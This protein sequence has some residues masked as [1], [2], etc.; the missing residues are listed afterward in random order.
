MNTQQRFLDKYDEMR[1]LQRRFF[2]GDRSVVGQAKAAERE[3]DALALQ[4]RAEASQLT[5]FTKEP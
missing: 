3:C 5:F 4:L 1:G 2:K